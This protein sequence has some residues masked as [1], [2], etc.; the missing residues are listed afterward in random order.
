MYS[1]NEILFPNAIIPRTREMRGDQWTE[2]VDRVTDLP[3]DHPE[4]MAFVLTMIRLDGCLDCE[5][6]SYR[7][8]RGCGLCAAQ[9]L[10]R[11]K[12]L[13]DD[14]MDMYDEALFD[15]EAFLDSDALQ[16]ESRIA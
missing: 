7:A 5:T 15:V 3:D 4:K 10:R 11:F 9:M 8:L 13:D 6:D 1:D 16:E 12:G 14:L 2:L